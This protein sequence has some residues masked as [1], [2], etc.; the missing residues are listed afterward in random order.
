MSLRP[1]ESCGADISLLAR[2]C[3]KCGEPDPHSFYWGQKEAEADS[4]RALIYST[5]RAAVDKLGRQYLLPSLIV[6]AASVVVMLLVAGSDNLG[7]VIG[8][9]VCALPIAFFTG[10]MKSP[11]E[12]GRL[13]RPFCFFAPTVALVHALE[14]VCFLFL[15]A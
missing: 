8:A 4:E 11:L 1:C 13:T 9:V 10:S 3:P 14:A 6:S 12:A 5:N 2:T 15:A 7:V